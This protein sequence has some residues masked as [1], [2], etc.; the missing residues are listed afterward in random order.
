MMRKTRILYIAVALNILLSSCAAPPKTIVRTIVNI[1]EK[2]EIKKI[3]I[4]SD[5]G[6]QF[7]KNFGQ[8]FTGKMKNLTEA[9]HLDVSFLNYIEFIHS[10]YNNQKEQHSFSDIVFV[11]IV[12]HSSKSSEYGIYSVKY[13]LEAKYLDKETFFSQEITFGL[14]SPIFSSKSERGIEFAKTVFEELQ[15]QN[16]L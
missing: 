6:K 5:V 16:I 15:S 11:F 12:P 7:G 2:P 14:S 4:V 3:V 13:Q 10:A 9:S 1:K 8:S